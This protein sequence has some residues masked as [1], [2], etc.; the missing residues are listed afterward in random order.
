LKYCRY[1]KG[2]YS[3]LI[4]RWQ[5]TRL[6]EVYI[7]VETVIS[8][9]LAENFLLQSDEKLHLSDPGSKDFMVHGS[10]QAKL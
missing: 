5:E 3:N 4:V 8:V 1:E 2:L 6:S 9:S 10:Q 7:C